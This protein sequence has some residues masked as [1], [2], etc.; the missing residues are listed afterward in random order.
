MPRR[1]KKWHRMPWKR[2]AERYLDGDSIK[3]LAEDFRCS[4]PTIVKVLTRHGVK[5]KPP[6]KY[7]FDPAAAAR[8]DKRLV[9][10]YV[11]GEL[12]VADI[13]NAFGV[14]ERM[15][16]RAA[17]AAGVTNRKTVKKVI[18]EVTTEQET[19]LSEC[20]GRMS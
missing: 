15:V 17:K 19:D 5:L 11:E 18:P 20:G 13:A 1:K 7:D 8:R 3:I 2:I 14:T 6:Q 4:R 12:P 16:Y 9:D 10:A